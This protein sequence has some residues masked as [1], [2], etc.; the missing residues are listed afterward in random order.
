MCREP[1]IF[2]LLSPAND[3][4]P[5]IHAV[6][7]TVSTP[8]FWSSKPWWCQPWS[9]VLTGALGLS[10]DWFAHQRLHLPLWIA[11]PLG[12]GICAWWLLFL[13]LVPSAAAHEEEFTPTNPNK[14]L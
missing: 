1:A 7:F 5:P 10:T 11:V 8:S 2:P 12:L 9:I 6:T 3:G 4:S 14:P 13:V